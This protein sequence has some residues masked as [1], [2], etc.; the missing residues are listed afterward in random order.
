MYGNYGIDELIFN[1][2]KYKKINLNKKNPFE[3]DEYL[4]PKI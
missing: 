3:I 1:Q 4:R 2:P